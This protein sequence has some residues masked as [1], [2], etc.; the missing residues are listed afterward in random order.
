MCCVGAPGTT[1]AGTL[2]RPIATGTPPTTGTTTTA[3]GLCVYPAP[4][5][6]G[7]LG[8]VLRRFQARAVGFTNPPGVPWR[9]SRS[10]PR[11]VR[12]DSCGQR[13]NRLGGA[14]SSAW[15]R[16]SRQSVLN[17]SARQKTPV[18]LR[19]INNLTI[20]GLADLVGVT[21]QIQPDGFPDIRQG[22]VTSL[23]LRPTTLQ[24]RAMSDEVAFLT[25]LDNNFD[26][27]GSS[28]DCCGGLVSIP[29]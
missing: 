6:H 20:S 25:S 10:S 23:A 4:A 21:F 16:T 12:V 28:P 11:V 22:F 5:L 26:C 1:T 27:H 14:S 15:S 13:S 8:N 7:R 17:L 9:E 19:Q 3:S 2:A 18:S 24:R 29:H